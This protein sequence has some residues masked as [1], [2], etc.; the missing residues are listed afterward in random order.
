[1]AGSSAEYGPITGRF[2]RFFAVAS[3]S[4]LCNIAKQ[5]LRLS[6]MAKKIYSKISDILLKHAMLDQATLEAAEEEAR[7]SKVRLEKYLI[8][9][10]IV[11]GEDMTLALSEYLK[12]PPVSLAH[13][14]PN[15]QLLELIPRETMIAR[16]VV[17]VHRVGKT[18][19]I[20]LSDPFDIMTIDELSTITGMD[21]TPLVA[22]EKDIT[23]TLERCLA[24]E[25]ESFNMEEILQQTD[26]EFDIGH[27]K[28]QD[29]AG[30]SIEQ[31]IQSA[32]G[33]PVVRMVNMMLLEA[34]RT[35][36]SD[37]HVEPQ[38][39][40]LVLRYRI[41]GALVERPNPPKQLQG[42][43]LSRLKLMSNMDI[44]ERRIPQDGRIKIRAL[45]REVDLRVNTLPTI[46]GEK[47]VL[48]ILDKTALFGSLGA[49]GLDED[50]YRAMKHA[51]AQPHGIILV[52][53]PTGSGKT[54]TLYSCLQ[55]LNTPDVNIVTC[56][57]PVEYQI[58]GLNQVQINSYVGLTFA[59]AL[60]AVMRQ[61]PD[62]ILVGEIRDS[63][64]AGIAIKA[65]LTGHLVLSTLHTNDAA[66]AITRMIDMGIEPSLL[67]SGL[68]LAQ[69]QRLCRRLCASC[70]KPETEP[71][72]KLMSL[73]NIDPHF[74]DGV[75]MYKAVGCPK[76][77]NTGY[78]GRI[79][80]M[81][82]LPMN[83]ELRQDIIKGTPIKEISAKARKMGMLTLKDIGLRKVK[84]GV[85]SLEQALEVTGGE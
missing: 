82:V 72:T 32:E 52:T 11:K 27:E 64:T 42:A 22:S 31:T 70:K 5:C 4:F 47:I 18:L 84:E 49:L 57:D 80:I 8:E 48:R 67:A 79:A 61:S 14:T 54:T 69:A 41:D 60:R 65:A 68:I 10:K 50:A 83:R 29:D 53:G 2:F 20:A 58:A 45:G 56:E 25:G 44:A 76:C 74:F 30:E 34:L 51:I 13:F 55:E 23:D 37:I 16:R 35:G 24:A 71:Q 81:E 43:I 59:A 15:S 19:T 7:N 78:K 66:G 73:Y 21:I 3:E 85:T 26:A 62:I 63:E 75:T 39:K 40:S 6:F 12:I 1:M 9:K 77:H 36:A 28:I 17:P 46:F 38:E 33:A